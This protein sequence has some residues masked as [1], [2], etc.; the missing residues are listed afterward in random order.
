VDRSRELGYE[1]VVISSLP[2]M[3]VAHGV[4]ERMAFKRAPE[5]DWSPAHGVRLHTYVLTLGTSV[6]ERR[7]HDL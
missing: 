2:T 5:R 3:T 1:R 7:S 4:Y 6:P